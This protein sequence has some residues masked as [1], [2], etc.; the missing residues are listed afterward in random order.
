MA[1]FE[2]KIKLKL[3]SEMRARN[4]CTANMNGNKKSA[5]TLM[6]FWWSFPRDRGVAK[7]KPCQVLPR[8]ESEVRRDKP[9]SPLPSPLPSPRSEAKRNKKKENWIR[10][11]RDFLFCSKKEHQ[12]KHKLH[13]GNIYDNSFSKILNFHCWHCSLERKIFLQLLLPS[14]IAAATWKYPKN[15]STS[16]SAEQE[17]FPYTPSRVSSFR[18]QVAFSLSENKLSRVAEENLSKWA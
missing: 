16:F 8:S 1:V 6:R 7:S 15:F 13:N 17:S 11:K 9:A 10:S 4:K 12:T 14:L 5:T 18:I 3:H 2:L